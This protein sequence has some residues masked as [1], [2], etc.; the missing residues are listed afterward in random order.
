MTCEVPAI[1]SGA[2]FHGR[3]L[4]GDWSN[5]QLESD[6][7]GG[8]V[9]LL[10]AQ[11]VSPPCITCCIS[12]QDVPEH[13]TVDI[14][15]S[16]VMHP[17]KL[18]LLVQSYDHWELMPTLFLRCTRQLSYTHQTLPRHDASKNTL[19]TFAGRILARYG[20]GNQGEDG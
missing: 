11:R 19:Q 4:T 15:P 12:S 1:E 9:P 17:I 7:T 5:V 13:C 10:R 6:H 2:K 20:V 8:E 16:F 14:F 3:T 18:E